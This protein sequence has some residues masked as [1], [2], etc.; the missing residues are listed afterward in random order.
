MSVGTDLDVDLDGSVGVNLTGIPNNFEL[1]IT[2]LPKVQVGLDKLTLGLD[3]VQLGLDK[4]QAGLDKIQI[5]LDKVQLGIDPLDLAL[6]IKPIDFAFRLKE[7]P[8]MRVHFP[9]N[10]KLGF[11]LF[12][13]EFFAVSLCGQGQVITEP[14]VPNPCE[15]DP[16]RK[17]QG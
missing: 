9:A 10:F 17:K 15:C 2:K 7:L 3:K 6:E 8:S 4:I 5:G 13:S 11:S 12:G 1:G 16:P 14:Y